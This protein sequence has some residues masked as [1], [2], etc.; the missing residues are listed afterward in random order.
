ME[1][2]IEVTIAEQ[3]DLCAQVRDY[4][5]RSLS[6]RIALAQAYRY[7]QLQR[8]SEYWEPFLAAAQS[9]MPERTRKVQFGSSYTLIDASSRDDVDEGESDTSRCI[10]L[11]VD[12]GVKVV[13]SGCQQT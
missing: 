2:L 12:H 8:W 9:R 10:I 3:R 4:R 7:R 1:E 13:L 5:K 11:P 6:E